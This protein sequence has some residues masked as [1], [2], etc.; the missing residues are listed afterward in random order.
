LLD[1]DFV[2]LLLLGLMENIDGVWAKFYE[3][4][5]ELN[6]RSPR[7]HPNNNKQNWEICCLS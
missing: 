2:M 5:A 3:E 6:R 4:L 7:K 1:E